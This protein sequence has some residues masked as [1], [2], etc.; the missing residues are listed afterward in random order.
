MAHHDI[1]SKA[2]VIAGEANVIISEA[3]VIASKAKQLTR[4][5]RRIILNEP[6]AESLLPAVFSQLHTAFPDIHTKKQLH[7]FLITA[8][9][10]ACHA[11]LHQQA[12]L[13]ASHSPAQHLSCPSPQGEGL[14]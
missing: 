5:A 9:R 2:N 10:I 8:T 6:A 14:G 12:L 1:S 4:F 11:W 3:D 13:L 7:H